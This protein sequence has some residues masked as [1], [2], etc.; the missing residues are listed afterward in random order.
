MWVADQLRHHAATQTGLSISQQFL[1]DAVL[2][3]GL[4]KIRDLPRRMHSGRLAKRK[5]LVHDLVDGITVFLDERR[6]EIR[7]RLVAG[8]GLEPVPRG[9]SIVAR[10]GLESVQTDLVPSRHGQIGGR[11]R[12]QWTDRGKIRGRDPGLLHP[13]AF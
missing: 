10:A 7:M 4:E 2:A 11:F 1:A 12:A 3:G 6:L 8:A 5:A 9:S 13:P